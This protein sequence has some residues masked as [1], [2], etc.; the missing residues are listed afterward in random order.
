MVLANK[1]VIR[2]LFK[3]TIKRNWKMLK[4]VVRVLVKRIKIEI[5]C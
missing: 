2:A 3:E 4:S 1:C 5:S